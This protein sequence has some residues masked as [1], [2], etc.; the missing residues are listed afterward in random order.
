MRNF[1]AS[2]A[3]IILLAGPAVAQPLNEGDSVPPHMREGELYVDPYEIS[4]ENA[5]ADPISDPSV[6]AAFNGRE[7]IARIVDSFVEGVRT[8]PRTER[9]FAASD[10]VRLTRTLNEQFCYILGGGCDYTGRDM[11]DVHRDHGVTT[12]EFAAVVEIL[13][14][15][16]NEEG[17]PFRM[18]NRFLAKLAPMKRDTVTR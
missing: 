9:I 10:W 14:A 18:Q 5:G 3:L 11:K 13:Q 17:V 7:G 6:L 12:A 1:S 2:V 15:A 16:M 8:D 4:N